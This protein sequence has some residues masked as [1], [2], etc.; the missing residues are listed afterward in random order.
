MDTIERGPHHP[1][2]TII[3]DGNGFARI[4]N[5]SPVLTSP[6]PEALETEGWNTTAEGDM[7]YADTAEKVFD[8]V[9]I[10]RSRTFQCLVDGSMGGLTEVC[11]HVASEH[12][13][14]HPTVMSALLAAAV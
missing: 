13:E 5:L 12:P 8:G 11:F 3:H 2:E 10:V 4:L 14:A 6:P 9:T 1:T 7:N